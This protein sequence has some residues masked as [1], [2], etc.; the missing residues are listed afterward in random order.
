MV[1]GGRCCCGVGRQCLLTLQAT[2][3]H[4]GVGVGVDHD[5][6]TRAAEYPDA[7]ALVPG[8][9]SAR[10]NEHDAMAEATRPIRPGWPR[11]AQGL[12]IKVPHRRSER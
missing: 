6:P 7:I 5:A 11:S 8:I 2:N 10:R 4:R 9:L 12:P 1:A 3:H